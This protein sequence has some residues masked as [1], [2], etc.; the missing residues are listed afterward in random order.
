MSD[1]EN[2]DGIS[3]SNFER[4]YNVLDPSVKEIR[5]F[6]VLFGNADEDAMENIAEVTNGRLF[7]STS[8]SLSFIF[9]QIR[10]YQ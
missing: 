6:T 3:P 8:E 4:N 9:K 10:G 1:G 2:T 5:T 7:D